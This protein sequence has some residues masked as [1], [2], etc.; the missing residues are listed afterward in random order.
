MSFLTIGFAAVG[1]AVL[2][3]WLIHLE[4]TDRPEIAVLLVFAVVVLEVV[5]Y[6]V[7]TEIPSGV[8]H[9]GGGSTSFRTLDGLIPIALL[10]RLIVRRTPR[11]IGA[12]ALWWVAF[13]FWILVG[14]YAG[15]SRATQAVFFAK[16]GWLSFDSALPRFQAKEIIYLGGAY[17]LAAGVP[18]VSY[19]RHQGVL[20]RLLVPAGALATAVFLATMAGQSF[21]LSL[22]GLK[23]AS[24][25]D[26][27]ADTASAFVVLAMLALAFGSVRV[28][29]KPLLV[30]FCI[31]LTLSV[32]LAEQRAAFIGI[33]ASYGLLLAVLFSSNAKRRLLSRPT[34][35]FLAFLGVAALVLIP[36]L[37]PVAMGQRDEPQLP[38]HQRIESTFGGKAKSESA[39]DRRLIWDAAIKAIKER[40]VFGWG[41]GRQ[42]RTYRTG[43]FDFATQPD[44]HNIYLD[45]LIR[46]G[47]VGLCLFLIAVALALRDGWKVWRH[48]PDSR[49]AAMAIGAI[50]GITGL[51]GKG[52]VES[53]LEKYR[54]AILLG[55]L[56][57][58]LRSAR[59]SLTDDEWSRHPEQLPEPITTEAR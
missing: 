8:F 51:L 10:A 15:P 2:L 1:A 31:P 25:G 41:L 20:Q 18:I 23:G 58:M 46:R 45:L 27:G 36:T 29:R 16:N 17:A 42:V 35:G 6:P 24:L 9:L 5:L 13:C 22:P 43:F 50:A 32:A 4:R 11:A 30:A 33:L 37:G 12:P 26:P 19:I 59:T 44:M 39:A 53:V 55:L 52:L 7:Q 48:H 54:L 57:G 21:S 56:L 14:M 38:F 3:G 49:V 28:D 47:L 40:P 34:E